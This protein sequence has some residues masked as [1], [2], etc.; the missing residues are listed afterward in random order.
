MQ[1]LLLTL[2]AGLVAAGLFGLTAVAFSVPATAAGTVA[3]DAR[4]GGDRLRTRFVTDLSK[5]VTFKVFTLAEP[6]RVIIDLPDVKFQLPAGLGRKGRGLVTAYRYGLI[7]PGRARIVID[8]NAPVLVD[9]SFVLKPQNGQ[10]ARLVI[11]LIRTDRSTFLAALNKRRS[12]QAAVKPRRKSSTPAVR[13]PSA[14]APRGR[15]SKPVIVVDPGHGGIDPG[16]I[17]KNGVSEKTIV[18]AFAKALHK[19]LQATGRYKVVLTRRIDTYVPLRERVAIARRQAGDLFISIHADSLPRR[20]ARGVSGATVYTLSEKASDNEAK[21]LAAKENRSDIIAGVDL[22][23]EADEV[24]NILIDLAQRET[25]NLS[26]AFANTMLKTLRGTTPLNKKP[27]RFAGFAVLKAPDVPS[28]LV[29]LGYLSNRADE[30][31][32]VS[33]SWRKKVAVAMTKAVDNYFSKRI[34]RVP[35]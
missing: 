1:R 25:K 15:R 29:E 19:A 16:A 24:T 3:K 14:K 26:I 31:L 21:A 5:P 30:K 27:H 11:D 35:F 12:R 18:F 6:Y 34:A 2:S 22:P 28:V 33:R 23:K 17:S 13:L 32:M 7:G 4:L 20:S 9:K 8:V 10:P